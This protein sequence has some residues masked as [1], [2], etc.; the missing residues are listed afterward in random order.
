[1]DLFDQPAKSTVIQQ[2]EASHCGFVPVQIP[3]PD[4]RQRPLCTDFVA[5]GIA[6]KPARARAAALE[7][8]AGDAYAIPKNRGS[9]PHPD[10]G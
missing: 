1:M 4:V 10:G 9:I 7:R 8:P 2:A 5:K 3:A 6:A